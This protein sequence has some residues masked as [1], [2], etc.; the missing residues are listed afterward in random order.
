MLQVVPIPLERRPQLH[1][2][3][4]APKPQT[5]I[6]ER[7]QRL[8][9]DAWEE[10]YLQHRRL[11]RGVLAGYLG[12]SAELEDV[13]Q[14]VF[15]TALQLVNAGK[16]R[17]SGDSSSMRAWLVAIALRL[18]RTERRRQAKANL[19]SDPPL[20]DTPTS[21]PLDP[22]S[23]QLL[24]RAHRAL[25]QLPERLRSPWLLRHLERMSL[26]E[27]ATSTGVS[28]ATV[29]RR[30]TAADERFQKLAQRDPVLREHLEQ[31]GAI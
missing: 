23:V 25:L 26:D 8:E 5:T 2:V 10:L 18:A 28:L 21:A 24:Q 17:L 1:E 30:L 20:A 16:V 27:I 6:A 15:E 19:T 12:Y 29:K 22:T 3:S 14:Q 31:G 9:L 11:I 13:A 4:P 7:L